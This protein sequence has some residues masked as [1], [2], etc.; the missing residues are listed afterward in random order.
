[1]CLF[2]KLK[3]TVFLCLIYPHD[4]AEDFPRISGKSEKIAIDDWMPSGLDEFVKL[5]LHHACATGFLQKDSEHQED[6]SSGKI[7]HLGWC[8]TRAEF[9][10]MGSK[11]IIFV[12]MTR[13]HEHRTF[14]LS[15]VP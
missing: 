11:I 9:F 3:V 2:F 7:D 1:M 12:T 5:R 14:K 13:V 10:G 6:W 15:V 4:S 8:G